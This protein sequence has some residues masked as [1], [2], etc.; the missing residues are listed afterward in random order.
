MNKTALIAICMMIFVSS[1]VWAQDQT[2]KLEGIKP[3]TPTRLEWLAVELNASSRVEELFVNPHLTMDFV[4]M[5]NSNTII[6]YVT[7]LP[8]TDRKIINKYIDGARKLISKKAKS[9]GWSSWLK[10]KEN[11]KMIYPKK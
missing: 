10:V 8:N 7:Y 6:I 1:I 2:G 11:L 9:Y 3:F 5:M 4:P